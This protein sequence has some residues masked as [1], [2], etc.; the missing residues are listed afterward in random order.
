MSAC[1]QFQ[2][3]PSAGLID[4][5]V[6][7][8][9]L[10]WPTNWHF[11]PSSYATSLAK[12]KMLSSCSYC[13]VCTF[14]FLFFLITDSTER[15]KKGRGSSLNPHVP[16]QCWAWYNQDIRKPLKS[17]ISQRVSVWQVQA[18]ATEVH[19]K[20]NKKTILPHA[21]LSPSWTSIDLIG[22]SH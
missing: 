3:N 11:H 4:I 15:Q 14:L 12:K 13:K 6:W 9:V 18:C 7:T 10:H 2:G 5:S 19:T 16:E 22:G 20:Q 21:A 8:K 1:T 17:D